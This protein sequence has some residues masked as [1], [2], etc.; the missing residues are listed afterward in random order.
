M[1]CQHTPGDGRYTVLTLPLTVRATAAG[2]TGA[3]VDLCS[4]GGDFVSA[5]AVQAVRQ[6]CNVLAFLQA[7]KLTIAWRLKLIWTVILER[8]AGF[9]AADG[10]LLSC[11]LGDSRCGDGLLDGCCRRVVGS[12]GEQ[13]RGGRKRGHESDKNHGCG[14]GGW[15]RLVRG[16]GERPSSI[17]A[18]ADCSGR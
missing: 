18:D 12:D 16:D 14:D 6:T 9:E 5:P 1:I 17:P 10:H 7:N 2:V 15:V 13:H 11:G 8:D 4:L 3:V